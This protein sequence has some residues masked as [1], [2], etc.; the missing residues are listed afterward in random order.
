MKINES[1]QQN[2]EALDRAVL[3]IIE[4]VRKNGDAA[5]IKLYCK[6]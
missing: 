5:L 6:I 4:D 2:D 1:N 3:K